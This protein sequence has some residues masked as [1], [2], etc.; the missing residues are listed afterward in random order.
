VRRCDAIFEASQ[1]NLSASRG[2]G[3]ALLSSNHFTAKRV[4]LAVQPASFEVVACS[5]HSAT[6]SAVYVVV[7]RPTSQA[8]SDRFYEEPTQLL[9]I[10]ATYHCQVVICG[11]FHI[12]DNDLSDPM[13]NASTSYW[14]RSPWSRLSVD[15]HTALATLSTLSLAATASQLTSSQLSSLVSTTRHSGSQLDCV[16]VRTSVRLITRASQRSRDSWS[17]MP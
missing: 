13:D 10:A 2:G 3:V 14:R 4:T 5:L 17:G 11:D 6:T 12:H 16:C 15:R 8:P 1:F 9:E 7:Y